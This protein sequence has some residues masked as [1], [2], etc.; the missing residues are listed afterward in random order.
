[1]P[2]VPVYGEAKVSPIRQPMPNVTVDVP[3]PDIAG[4]VGQVADAAMDIRRQANETAVREA[5]RQAIDL[6]FQTF[7]KPPEGNDPGGYVNRRGKAAM[8]QYQSTLDS[9]ASGMSRIRSAL[10]N[11]DQRRLFDEKIGSVRSQQARLKAARHANAERER[12]DAE[13]M[14]A[15]LDSAISAVGA[16]ASDGARAAYEVGTARAELEGYLRER[17]GLKPEDQQYQDAVRDFQSRAHATAVDSLLAARNPKAAQEYFEATKGEIDGVVRTKIENELKAH[18][19]EAKAFG[20]VDDV[21]ARYAPTGDQGAAEA[22]LTK[23]LAGDPDALKLARAELTQRFQA[24]AMQQERQLGQSMQWAL[25]NGRY[26]YASIPREMRA[27]LT[28]QNDVRLREWLNGKID[29]AR[30][31]PDPV[32]KARA[33]EI[34]YKLPHNPEQF[35]AADLTAVYPVFAAANMETQWRQLAN[36]QDAMRKGKAGDEWA[37]LKPTL[38]ARLATLGIDNK[39]PRSSQAEDYLR[40]QIESARAVK[41]SSL[42]RK[43]VDDLIDQSFIKGEL[44]GW[45]DSE[46]Y[47]FEAPYSDNPFVGGVPLADYQMIADRMRQSGMEVTPELVEQ[48]YNRFKRSQL[49]P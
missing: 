13:E 19:V 49:G 31:Q 12:F 23:A 36:E 10:K 32:M 4:A 2:K 15:R 6:E 21:F 29:A 41:G 3:V 37:M 14:S 43:E 42:S 35:K 24:Q 28:P 38:D 20:T 25:E 26:S 17:R 39:D 30:S 27:G 48:E 40:R 22:E 16:N 1:M 9:Y 18:V 34:M 46:A 33:D 11:D 5:E 45:W 7:D 47:Q 44:Q 8:E